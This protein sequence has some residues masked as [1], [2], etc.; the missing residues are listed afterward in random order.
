MC[1][2]APQPGPDP[3][4]TVCG[5]SFNNVASVNGDGPTT[6]GFI[7]TNLT[8]PCPSTITICP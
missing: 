4:G 3:T 1:V 2:S 5:A 8:P 6:R 7:F